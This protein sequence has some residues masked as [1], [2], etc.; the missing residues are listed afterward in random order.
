MAEP[1]HVALVDDLPT[2]VDGVF[3]PHTG[4]SALILI[5]ARLDGTDRTETLAHELVHLERGGGT[6]DPSMPGCWSRQNRP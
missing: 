4:A 6:S 5:D 3:W 2:G 1:L